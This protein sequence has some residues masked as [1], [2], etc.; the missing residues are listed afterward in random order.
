MSYWLLAIGITLRISAQ[1]GILVHIVPM[2]VWKGLDEAMGAIAIAT[3]SFS[4]VGTRLFMGWLGD[5]L[6]KRLLVVFGMIV[7]AGGSACS[8]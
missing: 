6:P 2:L 4:A 3:I 5:K 7:G 8:S 1:A